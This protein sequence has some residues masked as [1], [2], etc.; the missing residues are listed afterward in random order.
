MDGIFELITIPDMIH[1]ITL[2]VK[3]LSVYLH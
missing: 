3:V 1:P 2:K